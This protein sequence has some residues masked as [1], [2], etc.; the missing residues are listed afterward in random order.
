[1]IE[2]LKTIDWTTVLLAVISAVGGVVT[3]WA[4]WRWNNNRKCKHEDKK[5]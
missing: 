2:L 3:T 4:A 1:M 5:Q